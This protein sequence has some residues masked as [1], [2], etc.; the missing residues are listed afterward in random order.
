MVKHMNILDKKIELLPFTVVCYHLGG[1]VRL[2][3]ESLRTIALIHNI[4]KKFWPDL[5]KLCSSEK[6]AHFI[7]GENLAFSKFSE[8]K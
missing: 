3:Y 5:D 8:I 6:L 1:P 4:K 7:V 2:Q